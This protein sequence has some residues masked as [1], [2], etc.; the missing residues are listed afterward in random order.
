MGAATVAGC[1]IGGL[2]VLACIYFGLV[3][4][5]LQNEFIIGHAIT[6]M[7]TALEEKPPPQRTF[8][9]AV[10]DL[11]AR[12]ERVAVQVE[13]QVRGLESPCDPLPTLNQVLTEL[14]GLP[15]P[16][17]LVGDFLREHAGDPGSEGISASVTADMLR[18]ATMSVFGDLADQRP[19]EYD[20]L[21]ILAEQGEIFK[22]A[23]ASFDAGADPRPPCDHLARL[24]DMNP[25]AMAAIVTAL[26]GATRR[27]L[28]LATVLHSQAEVMLRFQRVKRRGLRRLWIRF[29]SFASFPLPRRPDFHLENLNRLAAAFDAIGEVLQMA[30][31]QLDI[32]EAT[33]AARLL[34]GL[35]VPVPAGLPGRIFLQES[36]AQARPLAQFGVWHRLAVSRWVAYQ[37]DVI[38]REQQQRA[39]FAAD[40]AAEQFG[41]EDR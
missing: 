13:S 4:R 18:A 35:R 7:L 10:A 6:A 38:A 33:R 3:A 31:E 5:A 40:E 30:A 24:A 29:R 39:A 11:L 37:L 20:R 36:L 26:D 14:L 28:R 19:V 21:L 41:E 15:E 23:L 16:Q 9:S 22:I 27:Q 8:L 32:G 25:R 34:A 12:Q 1:A 2:I 17:V